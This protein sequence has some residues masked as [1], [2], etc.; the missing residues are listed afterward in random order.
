MARLVAIGDSLTQGVM[1]GAI[2]RTEFSYPALIAE[3]MGIRVPNDFRVPTFLGDGLPLNI[4]WLLHSAA[5]QLGRSINP[6]EWG[7]EVPFILANRLNRIEEMYERG[8]GSQRN[9]YNG[10]YHNLAVSGFRV[11]DSFTVNDRR[12]AVHISAA[13]RDIED[14]FFGLPSA[15]MYRIAQHVLNPGDTEERR[16]W[17]QIQNLRY[18][19]QYDGGVE[20]LILFLGANDCLGTVQDLQITEA[21]NYI[22]PY[23]AE[24]RDYNLTTEATFESDY[25]EMVQQISEAISPDT[26]VFVGTIPRVTIPPITRGIGGRLPE[27]NSYFRYYSRFFMNDDNFDTRDPHLTGQQVQQI[28]QRI[29]AFNNIIRDIVNEQDDNGQ[30]GGWYLVDICEM[31]D[32]LA[33]RRSGDPEDSSQPLRQLL[34]NVPDHPLLS[35]HPTPSVRLF[36]SLNSQRRGGGLF[37]LDCFH[38]TT[39]GYGL[40]AEAFLTTMID[41]DVEIPVPTPGEGYPEPREWYRLNWRRLIARDSLIQ[42]PPVLWD[43]IV[44]TV[45]SYPRLVGLIYRVLS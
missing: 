13:E 32:N 28:D 33:V 45:E 16:D 7:L 6:L 2:S 10:V 26:K 20:N 43:D 8:P 29:T 11:S 38:P 31:L 14:D 41:A 34:C 23:L 42:N 24:R 19:N 5:S 44:K 39:I 36:E 9:R 40:I 27:N 21:E 30:H 4:E 15:P 35:L 17:T 3:A 22:E 18:L 37:S 25:R 1:N 12:C